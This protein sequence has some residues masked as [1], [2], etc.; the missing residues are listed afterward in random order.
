[1]KIMSTSYST[2]LSHI[3]LAGTSIYCCLR[4]ESIIYAQCSFASIMVN[5]LLGVWRWGNPDYGPNTDKVYKITTL[6]QDSIV[7]PF[8]VSTLW[9]QYGY[10]YE[11]ALGNMII[12]LIPVISYL[13]NSNYR[14]LELLDGILCLNCG[15][16]LYLSFTE[17]NY[18]GL[19]AGVS[20]LVNYFWIK[21]GDRSQFDIPTQDLF[22][23][24]MCFFAYFSLK[25]V[26]D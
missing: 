20:Y 16:L 14:S 7:L 18:F 2:A 25:A 1:M 19:A 12:P 17:E 9:I 3:V 22:N 13:A 15:V 11:V 6:L 8:I 10:T 5:S 24:A 21:K 23:Y 4:S 26:L